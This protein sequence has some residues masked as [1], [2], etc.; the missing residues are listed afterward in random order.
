[1]Y[2]SL[3]I[4]TSGLLAQRTRMTTIAANVANKDTIL[5]EAGEYE[6]F[7]RRIALFAAGDPANNSERG[8]HVSDI[9]LDDAPLRPVYEPG[10]PY[11]N[12]DGYVFFP[13]INP[14]IEQINMMEASRAYEANVAAIEATKSMVSVALQMI[15]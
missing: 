6:P 10:S 4:S 5:N 3:D 9:L 13:N 14:V 15:A 12:E 1:M 8:V 11:A 7:R 2:G